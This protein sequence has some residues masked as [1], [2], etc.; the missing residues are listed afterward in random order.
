MSE[1]QAKQDARTAPVLVWDQLKDLSKDELASWRIDPVMNNRTP[2]ER[3]INLPMPFG[4]FVV[5]YSDE[6]AKGEV[7]PVT[8]FERELVVWRGEDG[9]PRV[10]DA[11]CPHLGAHL[12]YGGYLG[13]PLS[14][15]ER[16]P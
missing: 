4:W 7:K 1:T 15:V 10:L 6:L 9:A 11:Y 16:Q 8:Y 12:G 5:C 2:E 14:S 3:G 13:L